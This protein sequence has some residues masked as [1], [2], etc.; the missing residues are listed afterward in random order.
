MPWFPCCC[1]RYCRHCAD[2]FA[3]RQWQ[4]EL[5]GI[6]PALPPGCSQCHELN[7]AYILEPA[8]GVPP[9]GACG[10]SLTLPQAICGVVTVRLSVWPFV[11]PDGWRIHLDLLD[12]SEQI[13]M[14]AMQNFA[15]PPLCLEMSGQSLGQ[16][17][18]GPGCAGLCDLSQSGATL[19]ALR[20]CKAE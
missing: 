1:C 12:R 11:G 9:L 17:Q 15:Q 13:V 20:P 7:G 8:G 4:V 14:A 19:T 10:W 3:P 18:P 2:G 5:E 6:R 16:L